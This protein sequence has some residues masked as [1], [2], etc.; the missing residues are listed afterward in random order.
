M[1]CRTWLWPLLLS[2]S[3]NFGR[4]WLASQTRDA[5]GSFS[6]RAMHASNDSPGHSSAKPPPLGGL[7]PPHGAF[8]E[9]AAHL[10]EWS[11]TLSSTGSAG[12]CIPAGVTTFFH[13][14]FTAH[15]EARAEAIGRRLLGI[16]RCLT[17]LSP[18][19]NGAC[20][21]HRTPLKHLK[22]PLQNPVG[23]TITT[24]TILFGSF[25]SRLIHYARHSLRSGRIDRYFS[26]DETPDG[27]PPACAEEHV[28]SRLNPSP[29]PYKA[30]CACST[31]ETSCATIR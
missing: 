11:T 26:R 30:A 27:S 25:D 3:N 6:R 31:A 15:S 1:Q 18:P 24:C 12:P 13:A 29:P 4:D 20:D 17:A 28:A 10:V 16:G 9:H 14:A 19:Q 23:F 8:Q 22:G 2:R 21:F 5:R 7:P